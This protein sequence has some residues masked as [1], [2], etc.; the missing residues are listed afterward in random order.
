ML[1]IRHSWQLGEATCA[2]PVGL[3]GIEI[4]TLD[5]TELESE[6]QMGKEREKATVPAVFSILFFSFDS[7]N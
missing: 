6:L 1:A 5:C 7:N 2:R 3:S 4:D